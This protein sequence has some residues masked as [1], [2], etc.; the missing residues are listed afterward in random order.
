V[1]LAGTVTI[2]HVSRNVIPAAE[3]LVALAAAVPD[4]GVVYEPI[5]LVQLASTGEAF[6]AR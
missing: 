3:R 6:L 4:I 2:S 1:R 5:M